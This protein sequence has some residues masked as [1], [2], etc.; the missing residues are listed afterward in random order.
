MGKNAMKVRR[1][2]MDEDNE[3]QKKWRGAG[4]ENKVAIH[5]SIMVT[6]KSQWVFSRKK[7]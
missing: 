7:L 2:Q 4:D 3:E 6:L 1:E 5:P